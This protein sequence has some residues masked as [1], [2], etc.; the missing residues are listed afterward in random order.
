MTVRTIRYYI[1][2][3][4]LPSPDVRGRYSM[5]DEDYL[6]RI[7]LIQRLKEAFLPIR[8]IRRKLE[9]ETEEEIEEFLRLYENATRP[10]GAALNYLAD[11]NPE[12]NFRT[13][14]MKMAP[15]RTSLRKI[16]FTET[17]V[18][19]STKTVTGTAWHRY[20]IRPGLELHISDEVHATHS[21]EIL[22]W[23]ERLEKMF[24]KER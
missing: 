1:S 22:E 14:P 11:L 15:P 12:M 2:E 10:G 9:T 8:E 18:E 24:K 13:D 5:Y 16:N 3:G 21:A 17:G 7:R 4:L 20:V 6:K 19:R 23:L